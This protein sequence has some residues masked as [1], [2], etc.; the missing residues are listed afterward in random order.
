MMTKTQAPLLIYDG[1]CGLCNRTVNYILRYDR[2]RR[3]LFTPNTSAT[4]RKIL[5][6]NGIAC[7]P[8]PESVVFICRGKAWQKSSAVL[9]LAR[10]L[11]GIH[12]L[13]LPGWLLPRLIRDFFYDLVARNRYR[14]FG[15][16]ETCRMPSPEERSRFIDL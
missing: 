5:E 11:G 4:A 12:L 10:E 6:E 3:I 13:L 9:M 7:K 14:I 1:Q 16:T 2:R 8:P 15:R